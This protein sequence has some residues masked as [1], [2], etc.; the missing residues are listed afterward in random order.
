MC[1]LDNLTFLQFRERLKASLIV[2]ALSPLK[3]MQNLSFPSFFHTN[4]MALAQGLLE[5]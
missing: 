4:M 2:H 1:H 3:S 5:G